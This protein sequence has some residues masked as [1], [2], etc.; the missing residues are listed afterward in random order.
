MSYKEE[1]DV[2]I[3]DN[4]PSGIKMCKNFHYFYYKMAVEI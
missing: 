4:D 2:Q 3:A 1:L